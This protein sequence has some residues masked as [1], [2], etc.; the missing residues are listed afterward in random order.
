MDICHGWLG[1]AEKHSKKGTWCQN[2]TI[3]PS[4]HVRHAGI[5]FLGE[6]VLFLCMLSRS[7]HILHG[8]NPYLRRGSKKGRN[9]PVIDRNTA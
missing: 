2:P 3:P 9:R 6:Y 4:Y 7:D 1:A 5:W 8:H